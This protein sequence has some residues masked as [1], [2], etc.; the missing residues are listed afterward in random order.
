MKVM[1][2]TVLYTANLKGGKQLLRKSLCVVD[3]SD[4]DDASCPFVVV[5]ARDR[6]DPL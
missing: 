1:K 4:S 6:A 3:T 2:F 5:D